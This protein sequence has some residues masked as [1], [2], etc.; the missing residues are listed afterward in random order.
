[1]IV[2]ICVGSSCHLKG[3]YDVIQGM[4]EVLKKYNVEDKI[5]LQA[6]FCFGKCADGVIMCAEEEPESPDAVF[7]HGVD[8]DNLEEKFL[9]EIYPLLDLDKSE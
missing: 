8:K 4:K 7:V 5:E 1:M 3:S 6:S 9:N 2:K